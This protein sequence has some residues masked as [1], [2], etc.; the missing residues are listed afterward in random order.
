MEFF[1]VGGG[2]FF[3]ERV[4]RSRK[5]AVPE[6]VGH[7]LRQFGRLS[8][9]ERDQLSAHGSLVVRPQ[10]WLTWRIEPPKLIVFRLVSVIVSNLGLVLD[11]GL[12]SGLDLGLGSGLGLGLR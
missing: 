4:T 12:G 9:R 7:F 5:L 6:P 2:S 1:Q 3:Q 8:Q 11:L 10:T